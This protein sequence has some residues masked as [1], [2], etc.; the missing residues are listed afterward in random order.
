MGV[1][2][3]ANE[4]HKQEIEVLRIMYMYGRVHATSA[5]RALS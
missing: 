4:V 3:L 5:P 1:K 2:L